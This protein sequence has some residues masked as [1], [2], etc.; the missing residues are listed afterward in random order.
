M[1]RTFYVPGTLLGCGDK[2]LILNRVCFLVY[3]GEGE[4]GKE[5]ILKAYT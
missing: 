5:T 3:V 4:V 2:A 1:L